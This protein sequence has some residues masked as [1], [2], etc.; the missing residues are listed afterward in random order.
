MVR[1]ELI[2]MPCNLAHVTQPRRVEL[3]I[4]SGVREREVVLPAKD[5]EKVG[6]DLLLIECLIVGLITRGRH[7][8]VAAD[9]YGQLLSAS[10][11]H[12]AANVL[13]LAWPQC[14]GSQAHV[15]KGG[16]QADARNP[17]ADGKLH[18]VQEAA[19]LRATLGAEERMQLV[20]DDV[21]QGRQQAGDC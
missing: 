4:R 3:D 19:Q 7:G 14:F 21:L 11:G 5:A 20:D 8:E 10:G 13:W 1:E 16:R 2:G 6:G 9:L 18:S 15:A 12:D 17:T